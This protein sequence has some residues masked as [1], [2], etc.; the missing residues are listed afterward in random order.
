MRNILHCAIAI[1]VAAI[2]VVATPA[3]AQK[4]DQAVR[5]WQAA[6]AAKV[7][8][9]AAYT[10]GA[11]AFAQ[12]PGM[13]RTVDPAFGQYMPLRCMNDEGYGRFSTCDN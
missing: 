6:P 1:S 11:S 7:Y 3:A 5:A 2:N 4:R 9:S 12:V 8:R 13:H 10:G